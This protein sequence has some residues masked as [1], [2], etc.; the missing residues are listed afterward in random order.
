MP[1]VYQHSI[2]YVQRFVAFNVT[3]KV[4]QFQFDISQAQHDRCV[5]GAFPNDTRALSILPH[6]FSLQSRAQQDRYFIL[7]VFVLQ[8]NQSIMLALSFV[9]SQWVCPI[10]HFSWFSQKLDSMTHEWNDLAMQATNG[11]PLCPWIK[12]ILWFSHK[13]NAFS[14]AV[15]D[16]SICTPKQ[17]CFHTSPHSFS[18]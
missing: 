7:C 5:F 18:L 10:F 8:Q 4:T 6:S 1:F 11:F 16:H 3:F 14:R 17:H 12:A 9:I 15:L 2:L 13:K